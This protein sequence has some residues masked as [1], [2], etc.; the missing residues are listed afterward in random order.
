MEKTQQS[1]QI[2]L[3]FEQSNVPESGHGQGTNT[4]VSDN[5]P[6]TSE[7]ATISEEG[8]IPPYVVTGEQLLLKEYG[9]EQF[10]VQDMILQNILGSIAGSSDTGK[11]LLCKQ[12]AIAIV[13]GDKEF[14]GHKLNVIHGSAI[15]VT[16][17]DDGRAIQSY[18]KK[19]KVNE[20][21]HVYRNLRIIDDPLDLEQKLKKELDRKP[22]DLIVI[23]VFTDCYSGDMNNSTSVRSFLNKYQRLIN[24]YGVTILITHHTGKRTETNEPSKSNVLGSQGFESK[25][26]FVGELRR[27]LS[28]KSI[29]H[30]CLVKANYLADEQKELSIELMLHDNLT[31]YPT[32]V[33]VSL[34]MLGS[35]SP[36]PALKNNPDVVR[37]VQELKSRKLST[38]EIEA[39]M[40]S[41]GVKI[42]KTTVCEVLKSHPVETEN[43]LAEL[44]HVDDSD[45]Q[46]KIAD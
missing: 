46:L 32:G 35:N 8:A 25:M 34:E 24:A 39:E 33:Q 30:L 9:E 40:K 38:R 7:V 12:L 5:N 19:K 14:L 37:M 17:E 6:E 41:R 26:R 31:F 11:S 29:R 42:G 15:Y 36:R 4:P 1:E 3:C 2:E 20:E 45:G 21:L 22:A 28:D 18:L 44:R 23:D 27:D 16:T 43:C 10:L 13:E